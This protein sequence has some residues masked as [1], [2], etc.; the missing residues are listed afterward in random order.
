MKSYNCTCG[1]QIQ[2]YEPICSDCL[3]ELAKKYAEDFALEHAGEYITFVSS[4][5]GGCI[6]F[7]TSNSTE[8]MSWLSENDY[9]EIGE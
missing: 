6:A 7:A 9:L 5:G 2:E 4:V 1:N 8:F 3:K